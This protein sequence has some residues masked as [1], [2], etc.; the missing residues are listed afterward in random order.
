MTADPM[1]ADAMNAELLITGIAQLATPTGVGP[2]FGTQMRE[3]SVIEKAAIAITGD[4][5]AWI[6]P[7]AE[8]S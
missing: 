2:K 8:W 4:R 6:G 1:N 7:A 5:F 3:L